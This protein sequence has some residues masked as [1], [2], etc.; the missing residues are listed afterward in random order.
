MI[1]QLDWLDAARQ[2]RRRG[3]RGLLADTPRSRATDPDTSH[4]AADEIRRSGVLG[5]QQRLVLEAVR[6]HPGKTAVELARIASL[7]R[8]AVSRRLPELQPIH[9]RRGP[10][11]ECS[12]N[13]RPQSTWYPVRREGT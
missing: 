3:S 1:D 6:A 11:R 2:E 4:R 7:D 10:P 5:K 9:V 12:I 13:G 8:Y